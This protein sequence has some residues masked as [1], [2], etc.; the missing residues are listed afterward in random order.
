MR[1]VFRGLPASG[2]RHVL[3]RHE[4]GSVYAADGY[5]RVTGRVGVVFLIDGPGLTN[6]ATAIA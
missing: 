1:E 3:T 4:Q 5:A 6:A 2:I